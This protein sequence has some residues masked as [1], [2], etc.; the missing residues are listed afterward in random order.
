MDRG[1][2]LVR[3]R[4]GGADHRRRLGRGRLGRWRGRQ[5][6]PALAEG[7]ELAA[8]TTKLDCSTEK[9]EGAG[10]LVTPTGALQ[11]AGIGVGEHRHVDRLAGHVRD[12][13]AVLA[14]QELAL[15]GRA[16]LGEAEVEGL[17]AGVPGD[18][19]LLGLGPGR[20]A[21]TRWRRSARAGCPDRERTTCA[22]R[23]VASTANLLAG[24]DGGQGVGAGLAVGAVGQP[25]P[26]PG[27]HRRP[28]CLQPGVE[29]VGV[30]EPGPGG[31]AGAAGAAHEHRL[32]RPKIDLG[33]PCQTRPSWV[34][35]GGAHPSPPHA[36]RSQTRSMTKQQRAGHGPA[37]QHSSAAGPASGARL[38]GGGHGLKHLLHALGRIATVAAPGVRMLGG[39]RPGGDGRAFTW[40]LRAT[41]VVQT[42]PPGL[43]ARRRLAQPDGAG[44]RTD[45][46]AASFVGLH[47]C[48]RHRPACEQLPLCLPLV[49]CRRRT[50][51]PPPSINVPARSTSRVWA[52]LLHSTGPAVQWTN[53][54]AAPTSPQR[55][56]NTAGGLLLCLS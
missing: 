24:G 44:H 8:P 28:A 25:Q 46:A 29:V 1:E 31:P 22:G 11:P 5:L 47:R 43:P 26:R 50:R 16:H 14:D 41:S 4:G 30:A 2:G 23:S 37:R 17:D 40:S 18:R 35:S 49:A 45:E 15:G 39:L 12:H 53:C 55:G 9:A 54:P 32:A 20:P 56:W 19:G 51:P 38:A 3:H 42:G 48:W 34:G 33:S 13:R 21:R 10:V 36:P 7:A 52:G 6:A 27:D